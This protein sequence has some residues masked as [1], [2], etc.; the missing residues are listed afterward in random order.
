MEAQMR[1]IKTGVLV[2]CFMVLVAAT[3]AWATPFDLKTDWSDTANP[4][5]PWS[6]RGGAS[7]FLIRLAGLRVWPSL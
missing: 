4:N 7:F 6:Y 1:A 3:R 2:A 5:G